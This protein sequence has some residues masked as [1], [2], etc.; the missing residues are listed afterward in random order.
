MNL[1][2]A[3]RRVF[4]SKLGAHEKLVALALLDHWSA[5]E[6]FPFPSVGRLE[7]WTGLSRSS[8]LRGIRG[9]R[10]AG[11]VRTVDGGTGKSNRYDLA[12]LS[13]LPVSEGHRCQGDTGTRV[14]QTPEGTKGRDRSGTTQISKSRDVDHAPPSDEEILVRARPALAREALRL[15]V[16]FGVVE[17]VA[18]EAVAY[19]RRHGAKR[20]D[21]VATVVARVRELEAGGNLGAVASEFDHERRAGGANRR[22]VD[23][24]SRPGGVR[25]TRPGGKPRVAGDSVAA[26]G[27]S[28]ASVGAG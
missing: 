27:V 9:L 22:P 5:Q 7:R 23:E 11:A 4:A 18:L 19:G 6:P 26:L 28:A 25:R 13:R 15:G 3:Q 17:S 2:K 20:R 12:G 1:L 21:W 16:P 24:F 8:V 10:D 14:P